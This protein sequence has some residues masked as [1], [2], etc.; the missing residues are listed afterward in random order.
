MSRVKVIDTSKHS[1]GTQ[2]VVNKLNARIVNQGD[3]VVAMTNLLDKFES[4]FYDR[5][6]PVGSL[7]FLGPTGS[8]KTL[9]VEELVIALTGDSKRMLKVDCSEFQHSHEIARLI[10]SPPGYLGHRETHPFFTNDSVRQA[11]SMPDSKNAAMQTVYGKEIIPFTVILFDEIEKASD[12]LWNLLLGILDKGSLTTGTNENVD[13]RKT[14]I[15]MTSNVGSKELADK[16]GD[17]VLGFLNPAADSAVGAE[18]LKSVAVG[19]A[20]RK[21][22]PEFL[23]RLDE[24]VMFN[25]LTRT[26]LEAILEIELLKLQEKVELS[27][28]VVTLVPSPAA[29]RQ[30]LEEGFDKKYN[31]RSLRRVVE[32]RIMLPVS[33]AIASRQAEALDKV[34]ID[35]ADSKW[36][37]IVE[38]TY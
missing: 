8:G 6:R 34:I 4:G 13:M 5:N 7:L 33:R 12:S 26:D 31:A 29:K 14:V 15:I 38:K 20:R 25:T 23:N 10:G 9:A 2:A 11:R 30:M 1:S 37:Y 17:G 24:I 36:S 3:A 21:F 19:A 18:E 16:V 35:Y 27:M 32:K 22:S 28:A